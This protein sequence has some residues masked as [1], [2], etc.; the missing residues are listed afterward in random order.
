MG[1]G[2]GLKHKLLGIIAPNMTR[3]HSAA[4]YPRGCRAK[5]SGNSVVYLICSMAN[6]DDTFD[7]SILDM[8]F[9]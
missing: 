4:R 9:L 2:C 1:L 5:S 6:A 3:L 8:S 7:I